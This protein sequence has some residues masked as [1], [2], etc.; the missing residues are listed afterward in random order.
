MAKEEEMGGEQAELSGPDLAFGVSESE[1]G[2]G[3]ILL[4]HAHGE[5]V[6]LARVGD[7]FFAVGATCTHYGGPLG[8]GILVG[9]QVRCPWHHG[10]FDVR[11]GEAERAPALRPLP[12]WTVERDGDTVRIGRRKEEA[13]TKELNGRRA[14]TR[15]KEGLP[16]SVVIVGA[17]AAGTAAAEMLRRQGFQGRVTLLGAEDTDPYDRPNCSKDYLAGN[18]PEEWMPLWPANFYADNGIELVRGAR[19]A[20]IDPKART[21]KALGGREFA[22]DALVLATG[23][24]PVRLPLAT[25]NLPHVHYLRTLADSRAIIAAA[26]RAKRAVVVGGSFIGLETAAS[27]RARGLEVNLVAPEEHPMEKVLGPDLG[28]WVRS[29]HEEH[30]VVFHLGTTVANIAA[31]E[32]VLKNGTKLDADLVVVGIGVRPTLALAAW[33]KLGV[34]DGVT[35]DDR[36]RTTVPGIWAAGD[37]ARWPD[38]H[39]GRRIRVEHWVV[40]ERQGQAA[41]RN[42]MGADQPFSMVPFFWSAHYDAVVAYVGHAEKWERTT[43]DG[44]P[45]AMDCTVAFHEGGRVTAAATIFRDAAS[46][47]AEQLMERDDWQAL[48]RLVSPPASATPPASAV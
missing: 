39:T 28:R 19:V 48:E 41:A 34:E 7:D 45:A 35:V 47:R 43:L 32:V 21:V 17:G 20:A 44:D 31:K 33:A 36:L 22:W 10:A 8:E 18:A 2:D 13:G 30:G 46:L 9:H 25:H 4:G 23:S 12:C 15:S 16:D 3:E 11:T 1:V 6:L 26:E 5:A 37:I 29:I 42:I 40:A 24:D 38:P 27:L 14:A